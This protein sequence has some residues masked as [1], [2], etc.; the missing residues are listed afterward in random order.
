[1]TYE[2]HVIIVPLYPWDL[3]TPKNFEELELLTEIIDRLFCF[4]SPYKEKKEPNEGGP[5]PISTTNS[6]EHSPIALLS[7]RLPH[8]MS[9]IKFSNREITSKERFESVL[10][11]LKIEHLFATSFAIELISSSI[12]V[13]DGWDGHFYYERLSALLDETLFGVKIPFQWA[14]EED[15]RPN[16]VLTA[17]RTILC[18]NISEVRNFAKDFGLLKVT[19]ELFVGSENKTISQNMFNFL[20]EP[21][22]K[23]CIFNP[24]VTLKPEVLVNEDIHKTE[25]ELSFLISLIHSISTSYVIVKSIEGVCANLEWSS[26][27]VDELFQTFEKSFCWLQRNFTSIENDYFKIERRIK[28]NVTPTARWSTSPTYMRLV[29]QQYGEP[30]FPFIG[31][32]LPFFD[33]FLAKKYSIPSKALRKTIG[34]E[35]SL[36]SES[37]SRFMKELFGSR[38]SWHG[39]LNS[40]ISRNRLSIALIGLLITMFLNIFLKIF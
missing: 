32:A 27:Y 11:Q 35:L 33:H 23:V 22:N 9:Q 4:L 15:L 19:D 3:C 2:F 28:R 26:W 16:I 20:W 18:D 14:G 8:M 31:D 34:E 38:D 10:N 12:D 40:K 29:E 24:I 21:W 17:C 36:L 39:F 1:M 6:N 13:F 5:V 7:S 30:F 25:T 37:L